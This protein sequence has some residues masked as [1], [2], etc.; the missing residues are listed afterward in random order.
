MA[1]AAQLQV[2]VVNRSVPAA[3]RPIRG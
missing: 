1:P 3:K 2:Q